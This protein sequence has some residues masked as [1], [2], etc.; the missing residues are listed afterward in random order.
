MRDERKQLLALACAADRVAW[1]DA[2]QPAPVRSRAAQF[3]VGTE[4]G[5]LAP[6]RESRRGVLAK[7]FL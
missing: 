1:C 3:G 7:T 5:E 6:P 2:C 4:T